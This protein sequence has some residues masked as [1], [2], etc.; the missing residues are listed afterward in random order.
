VFLVVEI[1]C[2]SITFNCPL[3]FRSLDVIHFL[4]ILQDL[5]LLV[6]MVLKERV[7]EGRVK[8]LVG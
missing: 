7:L 4:S 8:H 6:E 5:M 3:F 1:I 2:V